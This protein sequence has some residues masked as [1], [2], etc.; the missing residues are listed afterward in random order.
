MGYNWKRQMK[1]GENKNKHKQGLPRSNDIN[2]MTTEELREHIRKMRLQQMTDNG[3]VKGK[4]EAPKNAARMK[5]TRKQIARAMTVLA[6]R[7][8]A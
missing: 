2:Q 1:Q 8:S 7:V 5:E 4:K 6:K 3:N